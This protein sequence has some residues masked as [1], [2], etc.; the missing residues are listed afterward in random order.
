[1]SEINSNA[2]LETVLKLQKNI[3]FALKKDASQMRAVPNYLGL[4]FS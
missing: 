2:S 1:M 3:P 4:V